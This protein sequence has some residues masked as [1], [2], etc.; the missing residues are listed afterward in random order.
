MLAASYRI[1]VSTFPKPKSKFFVSSRT[2]NAPGSRMVPFARGVVLPSVFR[3]SPLSSVRY[4]PEISTASVPMLVIS[5]QSLPLFGAS[6]STSLMTM[7]GCPACG[8]DTISAPIACKGISMVADRNAHSILTAR[9][10][11]ILLV[12]ESKIVYNPFIIML[13]G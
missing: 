1:A 13:E 6:D 8:F 3:S 4:Q 7:D 9:F 5:T 10:I 12:N 2:R 11:I